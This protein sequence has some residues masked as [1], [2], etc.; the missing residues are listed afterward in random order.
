MRF[1]IKSCE[2]PERSGL[3]DVRISNGLIEK[4]HSNI[5][6]TDEDTLIQASGGLLLPGLHDHH[7]H[8][9]SFAASLNSIHCGPP[10]VHTDGELAAIL[11]AG[12]Q[13][14]KTN[15]LRG[16]GYHNSVAG[17]IS[18]DWLD[19]Y[20]PDRPARIQH[21]GGRLWVLNSAGLDAL[22]LLSKANVN[23]LPKGLETDNNNRPTG[24]LYEND[25][26]LRIA[27][28]TTM[29]A[30]SDASYLL[31]SCGVTGVTDTSP[32]NSS[33][34][35]AHLKTQQE[36]GYLLQ[37]VRVMG[38][39][40]LDIEQND[41]SNSE[42]LTTGEYKIHLLESE[43]PDFHALCNSIQ[44]A[45]SQGRN[46]AVHCVSLTELVFALACIE[47]VG[48]VRGD[49]I[50]HASITSSDML[51]RMAKIGLRV[52][53]QPHFIA[54]RGDQYL[55]DVEKNECAL[56]YRLQSFL[57]AG[58]PLAAGSDAPFGGFDPW[59]SMRA[60]TQRKTPNGTILGEE[61]CLSPEQALALYTSD[62]SKPGVTQRTVSRGNAA[63]LCLLTK[64][65]SEARKNLT[66]DLVSHTWQ[67]GKLIYSRD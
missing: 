67:R 3:Q 43:L 23:N 7:I 6:P 16:I 13:G 11:Q 56:L 33:Q 42:L 9:M 28:N 34:E 35:W 41:I 51:S 18:R 66:S 58:V 31:A 59:L 50:E 14:K 21:R 61:E 36:L 39:L 60:A 22:G 30:L 38:S 10:E 1:L 54:E 17:D 53:T 48:I 44:Q 65:W 37:S 26:W 12:N 24:R 47:E 64:P 46:I 55:Q 63:S 32:H 20:I 62:P 29:P 45:R 49:R 52:V 15:W 40:D 57:D 25:R 27:L 19:D 5:I 8:L 2:L 4:I